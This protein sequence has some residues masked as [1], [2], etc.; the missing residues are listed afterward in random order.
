GGNKQHSDLLASAS[1]V[2]ITQEDAH[3]TPRQPSMDKQTY[4][5]NFPQA[6]I[7]SDPHH[8]SVLDHLRDLL[9]GEQQLSRLGI[10]GGPDVWFARN[11]AKTWFWASN[12]K[13]Y[14][15]GNSADVR[16]TNFIRGQVVH[17]I[18]V[19]EGKAIDIRDAQIAKV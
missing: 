18:D 5:A 10:D 6:A 9:A 14:W 4:Q 1:G 11:I 3:K 16:N 2:L 8:L 17:I 12:A 19:L 7:P 13:D 15:N